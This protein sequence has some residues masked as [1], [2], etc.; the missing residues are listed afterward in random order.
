MLSAAGRGRT[1]GGPREHIMEVP[2][3]SQPGVGAILT[4]LSERPHHT[5]ENPNE[6]LWLL[7]L[8]ASLTHIA[9]L[10]T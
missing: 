1:D 7:A 9:T 3:A 2:C 10:A 5:N 4:S 8:L 6:G